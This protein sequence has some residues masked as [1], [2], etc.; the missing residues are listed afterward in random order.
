MQQSQILL[1]ALPEL[2]WI[3]FLL[4]LNNSEI[5]QTELIMEES[6]D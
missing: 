4:L 6:N 5:H 1:Y 2:T 3:F